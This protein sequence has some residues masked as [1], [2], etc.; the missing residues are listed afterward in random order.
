VVLLPR[1][2]QSLL[3]VEKSHLEM[4]TA[5]VLKKPTPPAKN[6]IEM[7]KVSPKPMIIAQVS[8]RSYQGR[9]DCGAPAM[10]ESLL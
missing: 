6:A 4:P 1:L 5:M 9:A 2:A 10:I 8:S 7:R 3:V